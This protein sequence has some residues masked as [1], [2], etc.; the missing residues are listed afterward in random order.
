MINQVKKYIQKSTF[1]VTISVLNVIFYVGI[2]KP[3]YNKQVRQTL[4]VH[5]IE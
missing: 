2:L 4:F 3:R 5:Y 1:E